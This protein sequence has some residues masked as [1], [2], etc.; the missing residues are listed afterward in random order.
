MD[1]SF[2]QPPKTSAWDG[3]LEAVNWAVKWR[4]VWTSTLELPAETWR[5]YRNP[6]RK[7]LVLDQ[8]MHLPRRLGQV[9]DQVN[10]GD[11]ISR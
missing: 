8:R 9:A 3:K 6:G 7:G 5:G 11:L 2:C 1:T 4:D 10:E